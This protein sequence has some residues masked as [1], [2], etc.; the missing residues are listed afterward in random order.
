MKQTSQESPVSADA[1][2]AVLAAALLLTAV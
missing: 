2:D 1:A